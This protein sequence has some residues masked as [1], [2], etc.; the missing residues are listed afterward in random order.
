[1]IA[2]KQQIA[3]V[4]S[5]NEIVFIRV[6]SVCLV[7]MDLGLAYGFAYVEVSVATVLLYLFPVIV[8]VMARVWLKEKITKADMVC[9]FMSFVGLIFVVQ[10]SFMFG[11]EA[12]RDAIY[13]AMCFVLL[14]SAA[15]F[16][17]QIVASGAVK[18]S[19]NF[20]LMNFFY[21][22]LLCVLFGG[23]LF[24]VGVEELHSSLMDLQY[25]LWVHVFQIMGLM[26]S[27]YAMRFEK[28]SIGKLMAFYS[29]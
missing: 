29:L 6:R 19:L 18:A 17:T 8:I 25:M 20:F 13:Y 7:G 15:C 22:N 4:K 11:G 1:M 24:L 23:L 2:Q 21:G 27:Y 16:A 3:M 26:G 12:E 14:A 5:S 9:A 10:P 28:A